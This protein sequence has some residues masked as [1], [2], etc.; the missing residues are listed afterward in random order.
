MHIG[1]KRT[2]LRTVLLLQ[3]LLYG[4]TQRQAIELAAKIDPARFSVRMWLMI[5]GDDLAPRAAELGIPL[6]WLSREKQVGPRSLLGL[7]RQLRSDPVDVLVLLTVVPNI[8]GRVLG[9]L[10]GVPVIVGTCRGGGSPARQHEGLLSSLADHHICNSKALA[11][12]FVRRYGVPEAS[13]SMIP[14]GVDTSYFRYRPSPVGGGRRVIL[15]VARMVPDKDH[16]TLLRAFAR[17]AD[18]HPE[19]DLWLVGDGPGRESVERTVHGA[20]LAERVRLLPGR[21]DLLPVFEQADILVLSSMRE[22]LPNVI[23]E[24]MAVGLPVVAT[25]V[26]G[27]PDVVRHGQTGL[28]VPAGDHL[29]MASAL[30]RL[31]ADD[32]ARS[33]FGREGRRIAE[34]EYSIPAMVQCHSDLFERLWSMRNCPPSCRPGSFRFPGWLPAIA[35][36]FGLCSLSMA[37]AAPN[38]TGT[39]KVD[40]LLVRAVANVECKEESL[41][42]VLFLHTISG[43]VDTYHF[44]GSVKDGNIEASHRDGHHFQGRAVG[45]GKVSGLLTTKTGIRIP[46]EASADKTGGETSTRDGK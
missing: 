14:N 22:G 41:Q 20:G 32:D 30:S 28:L 44:R 15:S 13:V 16:D 38:Y 31:I 33:A 4:G 17:I 18:R 35:L 40:H 24:A 12:I 42:G 27:I 3:D 37:G 10:T 36:L 7:W 9:R 1:E 2:P 8:W 23:L 34:G 6:L 25:A 43:R 11:D 26:G 46:I 39:W 45:Q 21:S 19:V 29:S 5:E